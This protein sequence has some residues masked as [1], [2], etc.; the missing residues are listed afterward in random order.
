ML[1][2][3]TDQSLIGQEMSKERKDELFNY[4][5]SSFLHN[6]DSFYYSIKLKEDFRKDSED[7][8]VKR[9]RNWRDRII[10]DS[11]IEDQRSLRN[12]I[13]GLEDCIVTG[14]R[15][16]KYYDLNIFREKMFDV[17]IASVVPSDGEGDESVTPEI[18]VQLR[19]DFLW[20]KPV[21]ECFEI[22]LDYVLHFVKHFDFTVKEV[23]ENRTD[24]CYH[25]NYIANPEKYFD[26]RSLHQRAVTRI[27]QGY[28]HWQDNADGYD[29]DYV[30]YG[31]RSNKI[32][33]RIYNKT[34]EVVE[35]GYK[36]WFLKLWQL[37]GLIS[38]Y[39]Y[40]VYEKAYQERDWKAVDCARLEFYMEYGVDPEKK[41]ACKDLL[42]EV[43]KDRI[44][45]RKLANELTPKVTMIMNV[46][47]QVMR[48]ATKSMELLPV[49]DRRN[50]YACER[51]Y[52]FLDNWH[53]IT[54]YLTFDVFRL[55]NQDN[56]NKTRRT[57]NDFWERLRRCPI[58]DGSAREDHQKIV[59]S[60]K[61]K[62]DVDTMKQRFISSVTSLSL[63]AKS[64][65]SDSLIRDCM[66]SISLI[67]DNDIQKARKKKAKRLQL[68]SHDDFRETQEVINSMV[69]GAYLDTGQ[70]G[71]DDWLEMIMSGM[72]PLDQG[73]EDGY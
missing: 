67:N 10:A 37:N 49:K 62:L 70:W 14:R 19:S 63:Y 39:D 9:F 17:F 26:K 53:Y 4:N 69:D 16:A 29:I 42:D 23:Q 27:H 65:N 7:P 8:K 57:I 25:S 12:V 56:S 1:Q 15:Y 24:F 20:Q 44:V 73:G 64:V 28:M 66:D 61:R 50:E 46:E 59:R 55:C 11:I 32:F 71:V 30:A 41:N 72:D 21:Q 3:Y 36:G 22:S 40:Y 13:P 6:I 54:E 35:M 52:K 18:I 38:R 2:R 31:K 47:Y 34:K 48:R 45:I 60:Y 5:K 51:I 68:F 58:Y 43:H 33:L